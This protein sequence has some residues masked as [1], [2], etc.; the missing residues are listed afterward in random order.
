MKRIEYMLLGEIADEIHSLLIHW[1][2]QNCTAEQGRRLDALQ[3]ALDAASKG[4]IQR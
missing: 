3:T 2:A 1:E 4:K